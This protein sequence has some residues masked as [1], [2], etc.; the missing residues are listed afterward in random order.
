MSLISRSNSLNLIKSTSGFQSVTSLIIKKNLAGL[1][2]YSK[3]KDACLSYILRSLFICDSSNFLE[4]IF[5]NYHLYPNITPNGSLAPKS[6]FNAEYNCLISCY[7]DLLNSLCISDNI[8]K[9]HFPVHI[10]IKKFLK[11]SN[12][13][14]RPHAT[15]LVHSDAW[16][17]ESSD[18]LNLHIPL[19]GDISN[20]HMKFFMPPSLIQN[21]LA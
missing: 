14:S 5:N 6:E 8:L 2:S 10:R 4:E 17:G 7:I 13:P 12:Q 18:A 16:A 19:F 15:E 1:D 20:N 21:F 9:H 11:S 3:F